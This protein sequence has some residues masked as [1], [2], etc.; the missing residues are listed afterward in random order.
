MSDSGYGESISDSDS[1]DMM[2]KASTTSLWD[3]SRANMLVVML[4]L[5]GLIY[6]I[7]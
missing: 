1:Y 2:P 6:L 3:T 5:S 4:V 7:F